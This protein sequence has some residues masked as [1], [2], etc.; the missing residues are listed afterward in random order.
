[1][2]LTDNIYII[3]NLFNIKLYSMHKVRAKMGVLLYITKRKFKYYMFCLKIN[4][5]YINPLKKILKSGI[6]FTMNN[7]AFMADCLNFTRGKTNG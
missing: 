6:I 7:C 4:D 5:L 2:L 3:N 1:M